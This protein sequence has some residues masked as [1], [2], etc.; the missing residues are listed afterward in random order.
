MPK[1]KTAPKVYC[2]N[3]ETHVSEENIAVCEICERDVCPKCRSERTAFRHT[4][5]EDISITDV[6][7]YPA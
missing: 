2:R 6:K 4:N 5:C 3:C 1:T 7:I